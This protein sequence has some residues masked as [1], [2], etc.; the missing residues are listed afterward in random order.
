MKSVL[1][2]G[3]GNMAL[4]Y[5]RFLNSLKLNVVVI[6]NTEKSAIRFYESTG[7]MPILGGIDSYLAS[8]YLLPNFAIVAVQIDHLFDVTLSLIKR[9]VSNVLVEKPITFN[10]NKIVEMQEISLLFN[11]KI[12]IA[13]NRRFYSTSNILKKVICDYGYPNR[14]FFSFN[15]RI[16][17]IENYDYS[18]DVKAN[19]VISNSIH[20]IDY[21]FFLY[22]KPSIFIKTYHEGFTS[23]HPKSKIMLGKYLSEFNVTVDYYTDFSTDNNWIINA[24]YSDFILS[25]SP[26]E[27][28]K[29]INNREKKIIE[30]DRVDFEFKPGLAAMVKAFL[31]KKI[32]EF[33][34]LEEYAIILK[35]IRT[36]ANYN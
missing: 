3:S 35:F 27:D 22:G 19:W 8:N 12:Y 18:E 24:F 7:V 23:W 29:V 6:G 21:V 28:I 9:G 4:D 11:S 2:I 26:I 31:D 32:E 20:I 1:L 36:I 17:S 13:L 16:K 25:M 5:F 10:P 33:I 15:D 30:R 14:V 34:T